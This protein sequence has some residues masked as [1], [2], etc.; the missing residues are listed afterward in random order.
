MHRCDD[1]EIGSDERSDEVVEVTGETAEEVRSIVGSREIANIAAR[2]EVGAGTDEKN[3][4]GFDLATRHLEQDLGAPV[5]I[6]AVQG[7]A[8]FVRGDGDP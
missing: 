8:R 7:V 5:E 1:R 6:T 4:T 2:A 3:G